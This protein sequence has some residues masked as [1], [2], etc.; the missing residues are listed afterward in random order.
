MNRDVNPTGFD[1]QDSPFGPDLWTWPVVG[2]GVAR[3]SAWVT[4]LCIK[5][6]SSRVYT[7]TSNSQR[8]TILTSRAYDIP[9]SSAVA[10]LWEYDIPYL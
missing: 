10:G 9:A 6:I 4:G 5:E 2:V 8:I 7:M 3:W 1:Q